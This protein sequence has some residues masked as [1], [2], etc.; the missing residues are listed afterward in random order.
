VTAPEIILPASAPPV[1]LHMLTFDEV[2]VSKKPVSDRC[3]YLVAGPDRRGANAI[4]ENVLWR[5]WQ[6]DVQ[7]AIDRPGAWPAP[8]KVRDYF[9]RTKGL[10]A[11]PKGSDLNVYGSNPSLIQDALVFDD[12]PPQEAL[13]QG[14]TVIDPTDMNTLFFDADLLGMGSAPG[15][16]NAITPAPRK[17]IIDPQPHFATSYTGMTEFML[18][19]RKWAA[20]KYFKTVK[21]IEST[22]MAEGNKCHKTAE[23][24]LLNAQGRNLPVDPAYLP[25]VQRY[26]DFFIKS[27]AKIL[28]EQEMCCTKDK[29]PCGWWDNKIVHIRGKGDVLMIKDR[30]LTYAD[31]KHGKIKD[32][33]FQIEVMVA[34]ADLHF[35]DEFDTADGKLIFVKESDPKKALVGL[36][37]QITKADIPEIWER[38]DSITDRMEIACRDEVFPCTLNFLCK[39]YCD[40]FT[41]PHNGRKA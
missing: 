5:T 33:P 31:W 17:R 25:K 37:K 10:T 3:G 23:N 24:Y 28:V 19:A 29:K 40:D 13:P 36:Q 7:S 22:A 41:C 20:S 14:G 15:P 18:C 32:D 30:K 27:G 6:R 12:L 35:G 21:Y 4:H 39:G 1:L 8:V 38:I 11:P 16:A 26:C 34:L 9:E 2:L